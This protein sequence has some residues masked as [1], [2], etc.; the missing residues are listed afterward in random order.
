MRQLRFQLI[1]G[2][3]LP[4]LRPAVQQRLELFSQR[5]SLFWLPFEPHENDSTSKMFTEPT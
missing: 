5:I 3:E 2:P 4:T 1:S